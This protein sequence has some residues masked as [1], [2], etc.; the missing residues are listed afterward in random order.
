MPNPNPSISHG[1]V[2]VRKAYRILHDYQR[3]ALDAV[4]YI[5]ARLGLAYQGG[6]A[7][8][9]DCSPRD[10]SAKCD[11]KDIWAWD[12]LNLVFY[13]FHYS[14][15]AED[16][17]NVSMWLFSD[18]GYFMS[19]DHSGLQTEPHS[20]ALPDLSSTKVA[21]LLYKK[22][23]DE[24][25]SFSRDKAAIRHFL[26]TDELPKALADAGIVAKCYDFACLSDER[27]A[28]ELIDN[29]VKFGNKHD[30]ELKLAPK[31]F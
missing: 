15:D 2:E 19:D 3:S 14:T 17:I 5:G 8:F 7:L 30:F 27:T 18:T 22:W 28:D 6:Y 24:F 12:W 4:S 31:A 16:G 10:A 23:K 20:F 25:N 9:S 13:D 1:L 29:L 11:P 26:E 21:F